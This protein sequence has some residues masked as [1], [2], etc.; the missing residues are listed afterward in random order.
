MNP[1]RIALRPNACSLLIEWSDGAST[2]LPYR[3]LRKECR[4][5]GCLSIR[6]GGAVAAADD[7]EL[8]AVIPYGPNAVQLRF[9]DGHARGIYPFTYLREPSNAECVER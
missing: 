5:A 8:L 3:R 1:V 9:S 6:R 2:D 4:C 7:I